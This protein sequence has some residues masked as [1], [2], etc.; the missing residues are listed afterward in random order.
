[1]K[2][3]SLLALSLSL[4]AWQQGQPGDYT[5]DD[6]SYQDYSY[7]VTPPTNADSNYDTQEDKPADRF[8]Q[9]LIDD[10]QKDDDNNHIYDYQYTH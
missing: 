7:D 4:F 3:L 5:Y 2:L 6:Y 10:V 1:M 9:P 8:I